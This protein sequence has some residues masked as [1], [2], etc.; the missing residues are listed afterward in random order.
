MVHAQT[1][2]VWFEK[3]WFEQRVQHQVCN[4]RLVLMEH[5]KRTTLATNVHSIVVASVDDDRVNG[6]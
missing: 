4:I 5:F 3:H 2:N 6:T 1:Y